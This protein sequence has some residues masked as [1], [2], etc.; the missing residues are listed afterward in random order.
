MT[1]SIAPRAPEARGR[2]ARAAMALGAAIVACNG[3]VTF[4]MQQYAGPPK[5]KDSIAIIRSDGASATELVAVDG[6]TIRAPLERNNRL[7]VEVLP[8]T[9][10][11]DVAAPA[12]GLRHAIPV[13]LLAEAGKVYRVE[14]WAAPPLQAPLGHGGPPPPD[15]EWIAH[16]YEV[17]RDTDA[18]RGIADA[19]AAPAAS[20]TPAAPA[21]SLAPTAP[22]PAP[23]GPAAPVPPGP[24]QAAPPS[25]ADAG[26]G[27]EAGG[28][29]GH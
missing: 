19:P 27:G 18:R 5:P 12:I 1:I 24:A 7:H 22:P 2:S 17:D 21:V 16:A 20:A 23:A 8:G 9:H 6:E 4:V 10:D 13:R 29:G 14:V 25:P 15:G 28:D 3:T 11:V 26:T